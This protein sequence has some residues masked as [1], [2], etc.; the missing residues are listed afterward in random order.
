MTDALVTDRPQI[1]DPE[2]LDRVL[3]RLIEQIDPVAIYLFGSRGR[4][5]SWRDSDY[6]LMVVLRN[7]FAE[8]TGPIPRFRLTARSEQIDANVFLSQESAYAWRR[9]EVGTLE[10]EAEI[11]GVELYPKFGRRAG[12]PD[13]S[14]STRTSFSVRRARMLGGAMRSVRS[15]T[16][17]RSTEL[18]SIPT[19]EG[20]RV[21]PISWQ[22]RGLP[23][24]R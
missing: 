13:Q 1:D 7:R 6:D 8:N 21:S 17:Q 22:S 20:G 24:W 16:K 9:H 4:G 5:D 18:S 3:R 23:T 14:K 15:S 10:Y 2:E 12:E 19:L 11:D